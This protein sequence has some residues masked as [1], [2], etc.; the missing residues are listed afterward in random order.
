MPN[1]TSA[2]PHLLFIA[3]SPSKYRVKKQRIF[4]Q[5]QW[6][7]R[8]PVDVLTVWGSDNDI[9]IN[10][11]GAESPNSASARI[12]IAWTTAPLP[13]LLPHYTN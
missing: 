3:S 7:R 11:T 5:P 10:A 12:T 13:V 4:S 9:A 1:R 6:N 2:I 8:F